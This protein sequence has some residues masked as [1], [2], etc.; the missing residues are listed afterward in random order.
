MEMSSKASTT[1]NSSDGA[2]T[3]HSRDS[4]PRSSSLQPVAPPSTSSQIHGPRESKKRLII[5]WIKSRA[6]VIYFRIS[7]VTFMSDNISNN[8]TFFL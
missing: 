4:V 2:G 8:A 6:Y 1:T 7:L 3:H 5:E